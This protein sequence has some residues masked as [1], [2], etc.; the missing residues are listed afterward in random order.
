MHRHPRLGR[1]VGLGMV[2]GCGSSHQARAIVRRLVAESD[3]VVQ[4]MRPGVL[5]RLGLGYDDLREIRPDA[6]GG[7]AEVPAGTLRLREVPAGGGR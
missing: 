3:V 6:D 7:E 4:N 2:R 1:G 5:D